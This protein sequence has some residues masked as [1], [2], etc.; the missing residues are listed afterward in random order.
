MLPQTSYSS[1]AL[2]VTHEP[3]N[4]VPVHSYTMQQI[5]LPTSESRHFTRHDA[6]KAFHRDM[7]AVDERSAHKE[8]I[9]LEK[10][11]MRGE[12]GAKALRDFEETAKAAEDALVLKVQQQKQKEEARTIR[13]HTDRFEFRFKTFNAN[14]VG[15][16][17]RKRN[18]V[19]W[20]YGAP[21]DDRKRG[22]VKIPTQCP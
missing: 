22:K 16:D 7:L 8:L 6:A 10:A 4:D 17:G 9:E 15:R 12:E 14:D 1:G 18:A 13:V 3:I 20:R 2:N 11:N 21:L 5:F 19:G